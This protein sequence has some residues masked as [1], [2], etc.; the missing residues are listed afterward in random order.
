MMKAAFLTKPKEIVLKNR[1]ISEPQ[2]GEVRVKL[3]QIGI[4]GSDVH[5]FQ[6]HRVLHY[7]HIIGHE[8]LG[9]ID[10]IGSGVEGRSI[11]ER[12]VIEPNIPCQK[13]RFCLSG[14]GNICINKRVIGLNESGC[15]AEFITLPAAFAWTI[16]PS[17]SDENAVTI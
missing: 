4:C 16:P 14:R 6:G 10:K 3:K 8:G 1:P 2:A 12:V 13:C 7:P 9:F 11:G 5:L 15:F 17:V